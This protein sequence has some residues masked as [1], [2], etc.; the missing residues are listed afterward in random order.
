[1]CNLSPKFMTEHSGVSNPSLCLSCRGFKG[2]LLGRATF[3]VGLRALK[4]V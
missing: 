2:S 1:M 3:V 4:C